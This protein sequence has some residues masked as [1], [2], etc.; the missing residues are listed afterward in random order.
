MLRFETM[1]ALRHLRHGG[2][3]T[4]LTMAAVA[5]AVTV[6]VFVNSLVLGVQ[7]RIL[8]DMISQ[9][10][11]ISVV[12]APRLPPPLAQLQKPSAGRLLSSRV[13]QQ[14]MQ[15][16]DIDQCELLE[17]QLMH[18][19]GVLMCAPAVKGQA[20]IVR[21]ARR[22]GVSVTAA[23]PVRQERVNAMQK[24][25]ISGHWLELQ[26]DEVLIGY[27]LAQDL[28]VAEGD[29]IHLFSSEGVDQPLRIAG[30]FDTGI[31]A[32]DRSQVFVT[33]RCGQ[34]LFAT[35]RNVSAINLKL[36]DPFQAN[37]VADLIARSLGMEAD[38]WMR[39]Q[40]Q[41]VNA[42][43][44]QNA[45]RIMISGFSLLASSFGIASVLVVSVLQKSREI[46]ILKSMGARD[47]QMLWVFALEGLFVSLLGS[48]IGVLLSL[49]LLKY[50]QGIHQVARFGKSNQLFPISFSS[51]IFVQAVLAA[52]G[53]TLLAAL[54]PARRASRMNPVDVMR[55]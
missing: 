4:W 32:Y 16:V 52:V 40:A 13:E 15:R 48:L 30:L 36:K 14:A 43:N 49:G 44:V 12:V 29:R 8:N 17:A 1:L 28:L 27:R 37:R 25:L 39:D 46:G 35:G 11:H 3:Q 51:S 23:D 26:E 34:N 33:M 47:G 21:G 9:I 41:I 10:P 45:N 5:S 19:P 18:F 24:N 55:G 50:L 42:F 31:S 20:F 38:S 6:M 2:G 22:S 53:A 54:L 7:Q